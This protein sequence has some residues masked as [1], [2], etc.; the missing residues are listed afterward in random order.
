MI[1][2]ENTDS[3]SDSEAFIAGDVNADTSVNAADATLMLR[4]YVGLDKLG[5]KEKFISDMNNDGVIN[6][7]DA[8]LA[9]RKYI[10][11]KD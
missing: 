9:L 11:L 2:S 3:I 4:D 6:A 10:G 1:I 7:I 8:T 5:T